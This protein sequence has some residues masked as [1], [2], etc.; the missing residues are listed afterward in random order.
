M[1][2]I[3]DQNTDEMFLRFWHKSSQTIAK[4]PVFYFFD[5]IQLYHHVHWINITAHAYHDPEHIQIISDEELD[6]DFTK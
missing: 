3:F 6:L 1:P 2:V 4:I 5:D